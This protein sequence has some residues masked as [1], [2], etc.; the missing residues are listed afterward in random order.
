MDLVRFWAACET[1]IGQ[2]A[3]EAEWKRLAGDDYNA[4]KA[5][6]R[7][8]QEHATS[9]PCPNEPQCACSH[10]VVDHGNGCIVAVCRCDPPC[11]DKVLLTKSDL[12]IYELDRPLLYAAITDAL[13]LQPVPADVP[14]LPWVT[15]IGFDSPCAGYRFP[16]YLILTPGRERFRNAVFTLAAKTVDPFIL[17]AATGRGCE[18]ECLDLL[19]TRKALFLTLSDILNIDKA[20][21]P[22]VDEHILRLLDRFHVAAIPA[23]Q[24]DS[25]EADPI[26]FFSTPANA[27]WNDVCI[28]FLDGHTVS[29]LVGN[30]SGVYNFVQMGMSKR[31]SATP[32]AQWKLLEA[33][34]NG[35]GVFDWKNEHADRTQKKQKQLLAQ[36]LRDFFRI[37]GDPFQYVEELKGWEARF[38][39][40]PCN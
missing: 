15:R 11:C 17:I 27:S 7:P 24:P 20:S 26:T 5:F 9:Y 12:V 10:R 14:G 32:T 13:L 18:P 35:H 40:E 16:V 28:R 21:K 22:A 25:R 6:L 29:V 30:K 23:L 37:D 34:A 31:N 2:A 4:A 1:L 38:D 3:V 36:A 33:F 39:I 8:L 19:N